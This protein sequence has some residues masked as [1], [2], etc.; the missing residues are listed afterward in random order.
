MLNHTLRQ[1]KVTLTCFRVSCY[2]DVIRP[3]LEV[4]DVVPVV[5]EAFGHGDTMEIEQ[6]GTRQ[7]LH[8]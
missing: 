8:L 6:C 3:C 1:F 2:E 5:S 4:L 7:L